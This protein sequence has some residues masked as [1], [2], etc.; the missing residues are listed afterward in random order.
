[1]P[2]PPKL[3]IRAIT[4]LLLAVICNIA[5]ADPVR[6]NGIRM[7]PA[8]DHTRVV[9][10][11]SRPVQHEVF[12]L[13]DPERIVIDF[14]NTRLAIKT[15]P[16]VPDSNR[17]LQ[18]LR[19]ATRNKTNLRMVL[20]LNTVVRPKSF[21][22]RPNGDYGHRLVIDLIAADAKP[23]PSNSSLTPRPLPGRKRS[24]DVIVV[25]DAGHGGEDPG[26][27]S[28]NGLYEKN[29]V[30]QI[31]KRLAEMI[32]NQKDLRAVLVRDGDY[33]IGLRKRMESARHHQADLFISIHADSARNRRA[34]GAGVYILSITG[35]SSEAARWLAKKQN[36]ADLIGGVSLDDKEET[37]ASV[38]LDLSQTA[39]GEASAKIGVQVLKALNSQI[40]KIHKQHVERAGFMVLK[41][42]DIPS[43][44]V[45]A[46]FLSS[47]K[48]E[49]RLRSA[50]GQHE[51][52]K[53]IL[54]GILTIRDYIIRRRD[55]S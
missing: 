6:I 19:S 22:L 34:Q 8:P 54:S 50:K 21:M 53:A 12:V 13:S 11:V 4:S 1:M 47:R 26:A 28:I 18:R 42:P 30:L 16:P 48:D 43:I 44:L 40:G 52:A 20:D 38:L 51:V 37:I 25:V 39:T 32:D 15:L 7:W 29:I 45:E 35:A 2:L 49:S 31:A 23:T 41:S 5:L 36:A 14:S 33:Y 27:I 24:R 17:L 10:D 46:G 55:Q 3:L 9:F